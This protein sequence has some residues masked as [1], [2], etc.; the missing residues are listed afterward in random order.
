MYSVTNRGGV[1]VIAGRQRQKSSPCR[2][3]LSSLKISI[4]TGQKMAGQYSHSQIVQRPSVGVG[5]AQQTVDDPAP[6]I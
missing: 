6:E 4:A 3:A 5:H 1:D 2:H